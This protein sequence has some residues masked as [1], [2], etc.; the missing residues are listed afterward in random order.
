VTSI[1]RRKRALRLGDLRRLT[2]ISDVYGLDRGSPIDRYYIESFIGRH[3]GDVRGRALEIADDWY[4]RQFGG[5]R[6]ERL[7]ILHAPPPNDAAT[8]VGDLTDLPEVADDTFDC[9]ILTQTLI[10][11]YDVRA[12]IRTLHRI[13][14]PGGVALVTVPGVS[15]IAH[16]ENELWGDW[17]RFTG[18]SAKRLFDEE[19]GP[20]AVTVD[21]Y[22]NVLTAAAQLYGI[23]AEELGAEALDHRDPDYEV[24]VAVRAEKLQPG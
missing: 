21:V 13:L 3:A 14:A 19:F 12:A 17:W 9:A 2:P 20:D 11:I 24:L 7:E 22:G 10:Y 15:R 18:M 16:P 4:T 1:F 5:D 6:V 23:A 8:I